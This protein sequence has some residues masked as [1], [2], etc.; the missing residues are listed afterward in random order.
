MS[1]TTCAEIGEYREKIHRGEIYDELVVNKLVAV[2]TRA[3]NESSRSIKFHNYG[4]RFHCVYSKYVDVKLSGWGTNF[5]T[6]VLNVKAQEATFN[7]VSVIVK[8]KSSQ[9]FVSISS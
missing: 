7:W 4:L 1:N 2:L 3:A 8:L 6:S 9:R 5:M